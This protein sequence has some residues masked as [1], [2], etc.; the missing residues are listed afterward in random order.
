MVI[1]T[2]AFFGIQIDRDPESILYSFGL[3]LSRRPLSQRGGQYAVCLYAQ[4]Q[5][6][7][8]Q[9]LFLPICRFMVMS[10]PLASLYASSVPDAVTS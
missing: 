3:S 2:K 7:Q 1:S 5:T 6:N 4:L 9:F 10:V 8:V